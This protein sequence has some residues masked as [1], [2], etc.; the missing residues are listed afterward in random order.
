MTYRTKD[1]LAVVASKFGV[2]LDLTKLH[3]DLAAEVDALERGDAPVEET[4]P[5]T[6]RDVKL[7]YR[8]R[9][10]GRLFPNDPIFSRNADLELVEAPE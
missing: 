6:V 5:E 8:H 7:V 1:Q 3:A 9:V 4:E 10:N 2:E